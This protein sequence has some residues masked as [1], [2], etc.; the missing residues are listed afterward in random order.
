R[1]YFKFS[2]ARNPWDRAISYFY[3]DNRNNPALK[4]KKKFYH[5]LGVPFDELGNL[6]QL[7]SEFIKNTTLPSNDPFYVMDDEL[8]V[9]GV[10]RYEN[11][12]EDYAK[13]CD[14]LGLPSSELPHLKG[15]IR[16]AKYHYS[17]FYDDESREIVA[18]H[19]KNDIRLF[20]Y[21]FETK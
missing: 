17:D 13:I 15:G 16:E 9:D 10:I 11:L 5:H 2:I 3:W 18:E 8:C 4:P 21:K 6:R 7:F 19:H 20:G 1:D 12:I 14:Q